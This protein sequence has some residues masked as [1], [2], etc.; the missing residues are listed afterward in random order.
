MP[1]E[2]TLP[3]EYAEE[4]ITGVITESIASHR[5]FAQRRLATY[6]ARCATFEQRY[7]MSSEDISGTLRGRHSGGPARVV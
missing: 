2:Y 7:G 3:E 5:E 1:Y 6:V 4:E